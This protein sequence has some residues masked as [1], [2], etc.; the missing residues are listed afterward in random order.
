LINLTKLDLSTKPIAKPK[1]HKKRGRGVP[2]VPISSKPDLALFPH[3]KLKLELPYQK[4][5]DSNSKPEF[6]I[7]NEIGVI[8]AGERR[9]GS[10]KGVFVPVEIEEEFT[11]SL[12]ESELLEESKLEQK[13]ENRETRENKV[14]DVVERVS[15]KGS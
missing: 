3:K 7:L 13:M 6:I 5:S 10:G 12:E 11:F 9:P 14:G 15:W 2:S 8:S 1:S 4:S